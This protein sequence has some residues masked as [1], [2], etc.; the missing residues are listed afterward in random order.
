MIISVG[1]TSDRPYR[2]LERLIDHRFELGISLEGRLVGER[3][4]LGGPEAR[5]VIPAVDP[6]I[7]VRQPHPGG[8]A[9]GASG[10]RGLVVNHEAQP[11]RLGAPG[12]EF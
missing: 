2:P 6:V 5:D 10:G 9:G 7:N 4:D 8:R 12:E 3:E 1:A 11:P